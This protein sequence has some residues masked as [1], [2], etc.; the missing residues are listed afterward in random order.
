MIARLICLWRGRHR[1]YKRQPIGGFRCTDC[2]LAGD[3]LDDMGY[4]GH[5]YVSVDRPVFTRELSRQEAQER[6]QR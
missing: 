3:S 5:G 6:S 4:Y 1:S 2:N